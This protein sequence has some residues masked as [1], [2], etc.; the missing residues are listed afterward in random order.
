MSEKNYDTI[1]DYKDFSGFKR[2]VTR[3]F[4]SVYGH[5]DALNVLM[6]GNNKSAKEVLEQTGSAY[7][8]D[9]SDN[10]YYW[11]FDLDFN[12]GRIYVYERW[13]K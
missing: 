13:L 9:N 2:A 7:I 6:P 5:T 11:G 8:H 1:R 4:K 10:N 12:T 3:A